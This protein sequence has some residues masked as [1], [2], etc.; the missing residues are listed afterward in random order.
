MKKL[1]LFFSLLLSLLPLS[2][3]AAAETYTW[4]ITG[5]ESLK[6]SASSTI[7][8]NSVT[9]NINQTSFGTSL[10]AQR[11]GKTGLLFG[12][13][14]NKVKE[15]V[16]S[17]TAPFAGKTIKK[18]TS[19]A[20]AKT[21]NAITIT[22]KIDDNEIAVS[23]KLSTT[24]NTYSFDDLN[25]ACSKNVALV[26]SQPS[27]TS[28]SVTISG[29]SIEY[30]EAPTG[31]VDFE[32]TLPTAKTLEE[33]ETLDLGLPE[34]RPSNIT[35]TSDNP[36][37]A[38]IENGIINAKKEGTANI[39]MT[40]A[41]DDNFN[42]SSE[43][44]QTIVVTVNKHQLV[45]YNPAF[46][47]SI[48]LV[49][50][51]TD[52]DYYEFPL[53]DKYP[54]NINWSVSDPTI[55]EIADNLVTA[56][57]KGTAV[58]KASWEADDNFLAGEASTTVNVVEE[59]VAMF[60]PS[61]VTTSIDP[62][63]GGS[64]TAKFE[65]AGKEDIAND[66]FNFTSSDESVATYDPATGIVTLKAVGSATITATLTEEAAKEYVF[67][68]DVDATLSISVA[69]INGP[70]GYELVTSLD[71]INEEDYYTIAAKFDNKFYSMSTTDASNYI[72]ACEVTINNDFLT[73][74][75]KTLV[76]K[77]EI[78][79]SDSNVKNYTWKTANLEENAA[80]MAGDTGTKTAIYIGGDHTSC[81]TTTKVS[82]SNNN[83]AIVFTSASGRQI[84][85]RGIKDK[86]NN[87]TSSSFRYYTDVNLSNGGEYAY[88]SLYRLNFVKAEA[89]AV[90]DFEGKGV[91]DQVR[92]TAR[93]SSHKLQ[94]R[95]WTLAKTISRA[96][97]EIQYGE[98]MD[99]P[100]TT[101][102]THIIKDLEEVGDNLAAHGVDVRAVDTRGNV[103]SNVGFSFDGQKTVTGIESVAAEA[104]GEGELYNLQGVRVDRRSAAPGLYIE[105]RGGKAVKVIL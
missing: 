39:N 36:E 4:T 105:R 69:D 32:Y 62:A 20:L 101:T 46:G 15:I 10:F 50:G 100:A 72:D 5:S 47:E 6:Q 21:A 14:S 49:L 11:S 55:L 2:L 85:F 51:N 65:A 94:Y 63:K 74:S 86:D 78:T 22:L 43:E 37:V 48:N 28:N 96:E 102:H 99:A 82:F 45:E 30:E 17:A 59:I 90:E 104:E 67:A 89:P 95:E 19:T 61:S 42:A 29:I 79:I 12:S 75:E 97:P 3:P 8:L 18:V 40:W 16:F 9:W 93:H 54:A 35:W 26:Y 27:A 41:A 73:P 1:L 24:S 92:F 38:V 77:P 7:T 84:G 80:L 66:N 98:W 87:I 88:V 71:Q 76:L 64:A 23:N 25:I 52:K 83:C 34:K 13:S 68:D 91:G 33:N 60:T 56:L 81:S 70:I 103:S 31:P 58:V 53:G 57:N 44:G